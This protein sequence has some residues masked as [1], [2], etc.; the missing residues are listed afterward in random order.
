MVQATIPY[1]IDGDPVDE[2]PLLAKEI[3]HHP[4]QLL[5]RY[6]SGDATVPSRLEEIDDRV[7]SGKTPSLDQKGA[8][9]TRRLD[10]GEDGDSDTE[11]E[12]AELERLGPAPDGGL[13]A[14][15]VVAGAWVVLFVQVGFVM[16]VGQLIEYYEVTIN[17]FSLHCP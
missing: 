7:D 14:W 10:V 16:S 3:D 2:P 8:T 5:Q 11:R 12:R 15:G 4:F 17:G 1:T 9:T 13:R 6:Y